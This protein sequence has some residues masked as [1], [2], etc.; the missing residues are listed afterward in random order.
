MK[1]SSD[2]SPVR[3]V[4]Y[5]RISSLADTALG[6]NQQLAAIDKSLK[7]LGLDL[8]HVGDYSDCGVPRQRSPKFVGILKRL[9]KGLKNRILSAD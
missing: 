3:Y 6:H 2:R 4:R 7:E 9:F 8:F 5:T 1:K